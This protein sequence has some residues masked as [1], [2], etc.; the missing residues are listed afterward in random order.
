MTHGPYTDAPP[1]D[2]WPPEQPTSL[3]WTWT[4][5]NC[6]GR[7]EAA[8]Y[9][10][11]IHTLDNNWWTSVDESGDLWLVYEL[12]IKRTPFKG[13]DSCGNPLYNRDDAD[14]LTWDIPA[15]FSFVERVKYRASDDR[16]LVVGWD[17][18]SRAAHQMAW[19]NAGNLLVFYDNW[20]QQNRSVHSMTALDVHW[21]TTV[22]PYG[23]KIKAVDWTGDLIFLV[24]GTSAT[25]TIMDAES[26]VNLT[27]VLFNPGYGQDWHNGWIDMPDGLNAVRI[28]DTDYIVSMEDDYCAKT[29]LLFVRVASATNLTLCQRLALQ[30]GLGGNDSAGGELTVMSII[31]TTMWLGTPDTRHGANV[32]GLANPLSPLIPLFGGQVPY[33]QDGSKPPNY[34]TNATA[35]A[36]L[37]SKWIAFFGATIGCRAATFPVYTASATQ[38]DIHAKMGID[39]SLMQFFSD[40]FLLSLQYWGVEPNSIDMLSAE[41]FVQ[42]FGRSAGDN[43]ICT[44]SDC[45]DMIGQQKMTAEV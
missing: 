3:S 20:T 17:T 35:A 27:A 4:D 38:H 40:Q 1:G 44:A 10:T 34:L 12:G 14:T 26:L 45:S 37:S 43:A 33:R 41:K 39:E 18:K 2:D 8:E 28:N 23:Q 29:P 36:Q 22:E 7:F 24:E 5:S 30:P 19:G 6:N 21:N 15:E 16:L 42:S 32:F 13:V 31:I 9:R 25:I 11:H